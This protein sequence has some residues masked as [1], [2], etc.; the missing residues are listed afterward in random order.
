ME[1]ACNVSPC[2]LLK[3]SGYFEMHDQ[4]TIE[5]IHGALCAHPDYVNDWIQFSEDQRCDPVWFFRQN[6][7]DYEVGFWSSKADDTPPTKYSDP[8]EACATFI[9]HEIEGI[10]LST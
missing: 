5:A 10:R 9:K 6:G 4:I 7:A 1:K 2:S 8:L 3:K